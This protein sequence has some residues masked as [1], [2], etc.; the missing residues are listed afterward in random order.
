MAAFTI[1]IFKSWSVRDP[2]RRWVNS[3]EFSSSTLT[4]PAAMAPIMDQLVIAEK[5]IHLPDVQFLS[6]T[7]STWLPDSHPYDPD[8][9]NTYE[10]TGAGARS[11]AGATANSALDSNA[12]YLVKRECTSG[13]S[14]KLFY[15]GCLLEQDVESGGDGRWSLTA[16]GIMTQG[17]SAFAGYL[18]AMADF[19]VAAEGE[20]AMALISQ[21]EGVTHIR[22]IANLVVGRVT[23]NRRNHRYFDR[24]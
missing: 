21:I 12:C 16:G 13:R 5:A 17:G 4:S 8:A 19:L 6:G 23:F 22:A 2:E 10:L 14:G 18:A 3:Y 9:F 24:A 20:A 11:T 15:R 1:R 7:I